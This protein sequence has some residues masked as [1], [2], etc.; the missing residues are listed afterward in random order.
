[1]LDTQILFALNPKDRFHQRTLARLTELRRRNLTLHAPDTA[2]LEFQ[3]VLRSIDRKPD[4]VRKALLALRGALEMN[5]AIEAQTF[6]SELLMRQCEI[7]EKYGLSYFDSL[8]AASA[9]RLGG[10]I[11]SDDESFDKV[12][13]IRRIRLS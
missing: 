13:D 11:L 12:P 4:V 10:E 2:V 3:V 5:Q 7:E 9:L 6:D 8:I 1:M